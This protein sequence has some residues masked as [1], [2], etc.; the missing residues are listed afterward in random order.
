MNRS[1]QAS[2]VVA[3]TQ[4]WVLSML[5]AVSLGETAPDSVRLHSRVMTVIRWPSVTAKRFLRSS[6]VM[7]VGPEVPSSQP[8]WSLCH[9]GKSGRRAYTR[10]HHVVALQ[11][12]APQS[13]GGLIAYPECGFGDNAFRGDIS[14]A[15]HWNASVRVV[16]STENTSRGSRSDL[17]A[18]FQRPYFPLGWNL[19]DK[20]FPHVCL[21][22]LR[23]GV[24]AAG[25]PVRGLNGRRPRAAS[26]S[27]SRTRRR[28]SCS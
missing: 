3:C 7:R 26:L 17:A 28:G 2:L 27:S 15:D 10:E 14:G 11:P 6:T 8:S 16:R 22:D 21:P 24:S 1:P 19:A 25:R 13:A 20:C 4:V 18:F 23:P 5:V 9:H 12:V